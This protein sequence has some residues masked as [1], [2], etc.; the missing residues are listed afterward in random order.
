MTKLKF[1]ILCL[2]LLGSA[3][4]SDATEIKSWTIENDLISLRFGY[5]SD[6]TFGPIS[7]TRKKSSR[8]WQ[9][10]QDGIRGPIQM[11]NWLH[12]QTKYDLPIYRTAPILRGGLRHTF[13][14]KPRY[15]DAEIE[16]NVE[17][18]PGQPFARTNFS[19]K[20][21]S[22]GRV[23]VGDID[24]LNWAFYEKTSGKSADFRVLQ[25]NQWKHQKR[26]F[27]VL[28]TPPA[29][30]AG[31]VKFFSGAEGAHCAWAAVRDILT[32]DGLVFGWEF[33]GQAHGDVFHSRYYGL[34]G[35]RVSASINYYLEPGRVF[36]S[37]R[38]F[39]GFFNGDWDEAAY[40]TQRFVERVL[41]KP[42][43]EPD[44]FPY[45]MFDSWGYG[46]EI[47]ES[48]LKQAARTAA[49]LGVEV[50]TVDLGWA[51]QIGDWRPDPKKFPNGLRPLSDYV[52]SLGMKFGLHWPLVQ[53]H[54]ESP[55]LKHNPDWT[56]SVNH[57]YFGATS[58]CLS[59]EPVKQWLIKEGI[60]IIRDYGV[61]WALQDGENMVKVC[62][63]TTHTHHPAGSN[64][65][66]SEK[67]LDEV[68]AAIQRATPKTV[69]E[70]CEDGGNMMTYKMVGQYV[71]SILSDDAQPL[72]TRQAVYGGTFPFPPRYSARYTQD[73][74]RTKQDAEHIRGFVRDQRE[75]PLN[76]YYMRSYM[77]GGPLIL[78]QRITDW[79]EK[80]KKLVKRE[81]AIYKSTRT[82]IRDSKV[83]HLLDRPDGKKNDAI[84]A[85]NEKLDWSVI[86]VYRTEGRRDKQL[87]KPKGLRE[88]TVYKVRFQDNSRILFATGKKIMSNGLDVSLP[89][90]YTAEIIYLEPQKS[91]E[92]FYENLP[93][94]RRG[95]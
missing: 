37:P 52:H 10:V 66:N 8:T 22:S 6:E 12:G 51:K 69:W 82:L 21:A 91:Q 60:R 28:E 55:A 56:S 29:T 50:F 13:Y 46:Q 36:E 38:S 54:L 94:R 30:D 25:V 78:M 27:E 86:F 75:T 1:G 79:S 9:S 16:F 95:R 4:R 7:F 34:L 39:I 90:Y 45:L 42:M 87:I 15:F 3:S 64:Y 20:N 31:S 88:N 57:G 76:S 35:L 93:R 67:G 17:V 68:I 63:K 49:R 19:Y 2:F 5:F 24:L 70:N 61:D 14:L 23:L 47:N 80:Q 77:F 71:T 26:N 83:I 40:K 81:L 53:A 74:S 85:Y 65:A 11:N 33:N 41:A 92:P 18:Y 58:L 59:H 48:L 44:K 32:N 62:A 43:P 84:Q 72:T 73:P 89:R